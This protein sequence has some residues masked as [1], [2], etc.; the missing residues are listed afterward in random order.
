MTS[1]KGLMWGSPEFV[2]IAKSAELEGESRYEVDQLLDEL[3]TM[4]MSS[5][6][7]Y[8]AQSRARDIFELCGGECQWR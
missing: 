4:E 8:H 7:F 2:R 5:R 6:T 3:E 1:V